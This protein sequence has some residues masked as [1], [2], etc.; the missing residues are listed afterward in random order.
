[1]SLV[2]PTNQSVALIKNIIRNVIE[3]LDIKPEI[4][5]IDLHNQNLR[6]EEKK[7]LEALHLNENNGNR[8]DLANGLLR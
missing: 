2:T 4:F 6:N 1:M 5:E 3:K 8:F 7:K